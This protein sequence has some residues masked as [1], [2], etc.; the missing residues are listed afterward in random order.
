MFRYLLPAIAFVAF[1]QPVFSECAGQNIL[2]SLSADQ[3]SALQARTDVAPFARGNFWQATKGDAEITIIG[4]YHLGDPRHAATMT[5]LQ[6]LITQATTLLVE[7]GPEEEAQLL[8]QI[9]KDPSGMLIT[10]GPS[11]ME[12]LPADDWARLTKAMAERQIPSFMAAK[13]QPWYISILLSVPSC[14][15]TALAEKSGLDFSIM[16]AAEAAEVP[17][18]ALEPF[19]TVLRLFGDMPAKAQVEMVQTALVMEDRAADS[20]ITLAD[21]YFDEN[22][23]VVWELMQDQAL[24][25]PG[26]TPERIQQEFAMMEEVLINARNRSWIPVLEATAANGPVFAAFGALHLS[27]DQGV[28]NLL[29]QQG[30]ALERLPL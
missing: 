20:A 19:D 4:T 27:G 9:T 3:R 2:A 14:A 8:A 24:A 28:L 5:I 7:A 12:Q 30:W 13:F 25:L 6:P 23:R 26:Y 10:T 1:S 17:I 18:R 11:L 21:A 22:S 16:A 15:M 29:A